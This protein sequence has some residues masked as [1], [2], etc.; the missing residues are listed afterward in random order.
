MASSALLRWTVLTLSTA[1]VVFAAV[2][3]RLQ[4]PLLDF[5]P[6]PWS[7]SPETSA[8]THCYRSVR[9]HD[10]ET[11]AARCFSVVDGHFTDVLTEDDFDAD[12]VVE[13]SDGYV[14]PGL[15]DGHGHLL[16]YGEFLHSVDLF[17]AQSLDEVRARIRAYL[18]KNPDAGTKDQWLRGVGWDQTFFGR[19]PTAVSAPPRPFSL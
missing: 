1:V 14:I 15:W 11:P 10:D 13:R 8:I 17:G 5:L 9:T 4:Q 2:A 6:L 19:M 3:Y 12:Q 7:G 16:Q 18:D